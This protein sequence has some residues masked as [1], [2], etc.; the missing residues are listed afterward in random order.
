MDRKKVISYLIIANLIVIFILLAGKIGIFIKIIKIVFNVVV[1]PIIFGVFLFY[2]LR[3][4]NRVFLKKKLKKG[5]AATLT[6]IIFIFI[7]SGVVK[8]FSEYFIGQFIIL[9]QVLVKVIQEKEIAEEINRIFNGELIN[10]D[11][12]GKFAGDIQRYT[13]SIISEAKNIFDKGMQLFSDILLVLLILFYL[14]RDGDKVKDNIIKYIPKKYKN[15]MDDA[16]DESDRVLSSYILGQAIVASSL[17]TMVYI[18]YK[19]IGISNPLFL[20]STTFILAFIPFIGFFISMII[21][22]IIAITIGPYMIIKLSLL[23]IIAQTLKGRIVVPLIMGHVM[24]IHPIT[25]IFLVVGAATLIG[26]I[27]AFVVVP[28]YALGKVFYKYFREFHYGNRK[29]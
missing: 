29:N 26:P 11:Y 22:Y 20:A 17:S 6:I 14:L 16:L 1:I 12:F 24:K 15:A 2:I 28:I 21:P 27:G 7:M 23:F 3:P 4:L 18:G 19:L 9:R 13:I 5:R 10:I 25:D 8:Y